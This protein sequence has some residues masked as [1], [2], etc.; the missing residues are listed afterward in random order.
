M[1]RK[2]NGLYYTPDADTRRWLEGRADAQNH[3][4]QAEITYILK[5]MKKIDRENGL[6]Y[7]KRGY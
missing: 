1:S 3:N 4:V 5:H 6:Y 7:S 2:R